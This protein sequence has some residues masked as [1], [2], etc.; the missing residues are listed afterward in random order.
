MFIIL[1]PF[2]E[3]IFFDLSCCF[4]SLVVRIYSGG[5]GFGDGIVAILSLFIHLEPL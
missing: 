5:Y 4:A 1:H 3:R 2:I